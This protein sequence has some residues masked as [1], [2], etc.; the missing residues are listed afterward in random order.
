MAL[1]IGNISQ[2]PGE[3]LSFS[4]V[5]PAE[6]LGSDWK[7]DENHF[8]VMRVSRPR[9]LETSASATRSHWKARPCLEFITAA[10]E[11]LP[12]STRKL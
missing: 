4:G 6:N 7:L 10:I 3:L 2:R 5:P 12:S 11:D 9:T 8:A 1:V